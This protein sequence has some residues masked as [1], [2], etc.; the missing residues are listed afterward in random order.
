MK[1]HKELLFNKGYDSD[2]YLPF[3]DK[4]ADMG[5][6]LDQYY[7]VPIQFSHLLPP[8]NNTVNLV[9]ANILSTSQMTDTKA[10]A[11][12]VCQLKQELKKQGCPVSGKN[13]ELQFCLL[14]ALKMIFLW[15]CWKMCPIGI[16]VLTAWPQLHFGS[17]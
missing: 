1:N 9:K 16:Q 5:D 15:G 8:S 12:N 7:E 2:N 14:E 4:V 17:S 13:V 3:F 10:K 6:N 11:L